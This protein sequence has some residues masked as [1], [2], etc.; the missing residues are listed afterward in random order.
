[1]TARPQVIVQLYSWNTR[2]I[3]YDRQVLAARPH[4]TATGSEFT[5]CASSSSSASAAT[6]NDGRENNTSNHSL[7]YN[8]VTILLRDICRG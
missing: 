4:A 6:A 3:N 2:C 8:E 5:C 1:M 7:G